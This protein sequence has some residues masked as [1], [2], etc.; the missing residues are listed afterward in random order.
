MFPLLVLTVIDL[1]KMSSYLIKTSNA[2]LDPLWNDLY[3]SYLDTP[4]YDRDINKPLTIKVFYEE[5][6]Q[7]NY[8]APAILV[9]VI[10]CVFVDYI[11]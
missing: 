3:S 2:F 11:L 5:N 7:L 8:I 1:I 6:P 9:Y 4:M 10:I